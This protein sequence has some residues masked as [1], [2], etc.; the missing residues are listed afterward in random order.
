[1]IAV[2]APPSAVRS[3]LADALGDE[4]LVL[5][6][7]DLSALVGS[8]SGVERMF[9]AV[10]DPVLAADVVSAAEMALVYYCVSLHDVPA[11]SG[12]ALRARILDPDPSAEPREIAALAAEALRDDPPPP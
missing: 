5:E 7:D 8:L 11:L 9:L 1:V 3:A 10:D 12:S 6:P 2:V 4:A